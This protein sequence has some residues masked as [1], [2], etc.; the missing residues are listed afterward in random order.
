MD[1]PLSQQQQHAF[2][3][4]LAHTTMPFGKYRGRFLD[5]LP[6]EYILWLKRKAQLSGELAF[7]MDNIYEIKLNGLEGLMRSIRSKTV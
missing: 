4:K 5:Q 7:M 2:L 1:A 3:Q 6:D